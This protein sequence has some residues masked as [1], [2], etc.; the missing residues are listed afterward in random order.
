MVGLIY[1]MQNDEDQ[2]RE[3]FERVMELDPRAAVAANNLAWMYAEEGNNLDVALQLA[4]TA[5][6]GLPD[7]AEVN[8]TLGWVYLKKGQ[9]HLAVSSLR[10]AANLAPGSASIRYRLG[11]AYAR[12][13]DRERA[14]EALTTAL[15]LDPNFDA[16][17]E[18]RRLLATL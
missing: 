17:V 11:V 9:L 18:T 14:R 7:S 10:E 8:D 1:Q 6:A 2:A 12:A 4:Q 3:A 13:G 16:A 15:K 5:R